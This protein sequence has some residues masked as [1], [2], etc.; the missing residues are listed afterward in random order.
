MQNH[1]PYAGRY[2]DPVRIKEPRHSGTLGQYVRGLTHSDDA[3]RSFIGRL[4][5]SEEKTVVVMYGD[6]FPS[7]YPASI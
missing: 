4:E 1:M 5:K 6:H 3:L 7:A 2:D